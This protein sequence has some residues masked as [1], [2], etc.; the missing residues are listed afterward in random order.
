MEQKFNLY[1]KLQFLLEDK[2]ENLL[3]ILLRN[4]T[5]SEKI[6]NYCI[7]NYELN[8]VGDYLLDGDSESVWIEFYVG[9]KLVE[10]TLYNLNCDSD[11]IYS[12]INN[13]LYTYHSISILTTNETISISIDLF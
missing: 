9:E 3:N 8:N 1:E 2:A 13:E 11:I 6:G 4:Y 12:D 10:S 7:Y 5:N